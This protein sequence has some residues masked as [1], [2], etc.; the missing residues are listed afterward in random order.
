M[1]VDV[2]YDFFVYHFLGAHLERGGH[3]VLE[4]GTG[5]Q[6]RHLLEREGVGFQQTDL[7]SERNRP[8]DNGPQRGGFQD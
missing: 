5:L 2:F 1:S 6:K 3:P 8:L 4:G 7:I